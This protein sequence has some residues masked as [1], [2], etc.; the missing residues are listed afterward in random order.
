M[1]VPV[2][3][4]LP[5]VSVLLPVAVIASLMVTAKLVVFPTTVKFP[6][7]SALT[8]TDA[9]MFAVPVTVS[10]EPLRLQL[11]PGLEV[12]PEEEMVKF[13]AFDI[14]LN[15]N[16]VLNSNLIIFVVFI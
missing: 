4:A 11:V 7:A 6:F 12:R 15:R 16:N 9:R 14:V 13:C 10:V 1:I 8:I 2:F 3:V 5:T